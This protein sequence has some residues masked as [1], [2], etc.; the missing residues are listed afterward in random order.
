[1]ARWLSIAILVG[2]T[3]QAESP[4]A[5]VGGKAFVDR[6][7]PPSYRLLDEAEAAQVSLGRS[8]FDTQWAPAGTPDVGERLESG[9][10]T[11]RL[12][13]MHATT[14]EKGVGDLTAMVRRRPPW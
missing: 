2:L 8:V 14:R 6:R 3:A 11:T 13:A 4:D 9:P 12:R 10:C 1:M 5:P 7:N